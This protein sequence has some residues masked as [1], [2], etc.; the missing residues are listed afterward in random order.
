MA[1]RELK[2]LGRATYLLRHNLR[3]VKKGF[4]HSSAVTCQLFTGHAGSNPAGDSMYDQLYETLSSA[5]QDAA[6]RPS[7]A[8]ASGSNEMVAK[9]FS[10]FPDDINYAIEICKSCNVQKECLDGAMARQEPHGV[11][12]GY[13]LLHGKIVIFKRPLGRSKKE[14]VGKNMLSYGPEDVPVQF[15]SRTKDTRR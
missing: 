3:D 15:R 11:W 12:G 5:M 7:G 4:R 10:D 13:L 1:H 2:I 9:F 14:D 6:E 8:C